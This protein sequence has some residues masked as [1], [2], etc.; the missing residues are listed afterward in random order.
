MATILVVD[1]ELSD[2]ELVAHVLR[3][4]GHAVLVASDYI[5]AINVF[6]DHKE[7]ID[8]LVA[9]VAIPDQ[10]GCELA[11][12]L[13][14][15]KPDL[16]VLLISGLVGTEVC[17]HYGIEVTAQHFLSKPLLSHALA[18]RV[19]EILRSPHKSPFSAGPKVRTAT[20]PM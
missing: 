18:G 16:A 17:K 4:A 20:E 6:R 10:N 2:L 1:D 9:D 13:L 14:D 12:S 15:K 19:D 5:Q 11:K 7:R 3:R 8:L